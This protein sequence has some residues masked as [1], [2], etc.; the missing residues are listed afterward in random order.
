MHKHKRAAKIKGIGGM[1]KTAALG[2]L[3]RH[4]PDGHSKVRVKVV[5][6]TL[7]ATLAPE[8]RQ[9]VEPGASLYTDALAS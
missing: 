5:P 9:N 3:E 6:N 8:V 4:G 1:G 7:R 2:L